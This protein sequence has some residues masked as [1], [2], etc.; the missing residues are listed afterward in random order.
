MMLRNATII[1]SAA[2]MLSACAPGSG[3][4]QRQGA[5]AILGALAGAAAGTLVGG[6][7]RRNALVGAGVGLLAGAAV[8]TYLD[9]Q[10][11][12]LNEDLQGTGADV[13]RV[14]DSLLVTLPEGVTF[15]TGSSE[16]KPRFSRSLTQ[17]A[18]TLNAYPESYI[19]V[20]GHTDST[21]ADDFNQRLSEAR[22][23]AVRRAL[24]QRS[25]SPARVVAYGMGEKAPVAD[26]A[27]A[28][29]RAQNR[30]VEILI[31]PATGN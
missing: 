3:P 25:V 24:V 15:D 11:A 4:S 10:E 17:V 26:N 30:R 18:Q 22:A 31:T 28:Q 27:T 8:G 2:A 7:D 9:Q 19:D 29:G 5:G 23:E 14:N 16:I 12:Q 1:L 13:T 6:N 20:V 21:G